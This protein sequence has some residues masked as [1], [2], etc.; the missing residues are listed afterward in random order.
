MSKEKK[1]KV[2]L[3]IPSLPDIIFVVE[4]NEHILVIGG[5]IAEC[6]FPFYRF[7]NA[8]DA[9]FEAADAIAV[10]TKKLVIDAVNFF[11]YDPFI[12]DPVAVE[13][14]MKKLFTFVDELQSHNKF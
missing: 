12:Y 4:M 9:A 2:N 8:H 5:P 3:T 14:H 1:E 11:V 6:V 13:E 10:A 7:D